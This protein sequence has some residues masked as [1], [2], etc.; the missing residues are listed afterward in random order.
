M[1]QGSQ[2]RENS[3]LQHSPWHPQTLMSLQQLYCQAL[4]CQHLPAHLPLHIAVES[5]FT[6]PTD[7]H[8][9]WAGSGRGGCLLR[10]RRDHLSLHLLKGTDT[11]STSMLWDQLWNTSVLKNI[12][13]YIFHIHNIYSCSFL[14]SYIGLIDLGFLKVAVQSWPQP[15]GERLLCKAHGSDFHRG[16]WLHFRCK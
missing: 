15:L 1:L 9:W 16:S 10:K 14:S 6:R 2:Q 8:S 4:M 13:I 7:F 5:K 12:Y 11:T 3:Y